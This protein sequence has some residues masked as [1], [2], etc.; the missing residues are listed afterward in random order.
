VGTRKERTVSQNFTIDQERRALEELALIYSTEIQP[1]F[2]SLGTCVYAAVLASRTLDEIGLKCTHS[3]VDAYFFG[4]DQIQKDEFTRWTL[5]RSKWVG[6]CS[7]N[8]VVRRFYSPGLGGGVDGHFIIETDNFFVDFTAPQFDSPRHQLR[9]PRALIVPLGDLRE[10]GKGVWSVPIPQGRYIF[11]D[12][13]KPKPPTFWSSIDSFFSPIV[14]ECV[15]R[16]K[17]AALDD[18]Y[19]AFADM[20]SLVSAGIN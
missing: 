13:E 20:K 15:H 5:P 7:T 1:E 9:I 4:F 18:S 6:A 10:L 12:A 11:C 16:M 17:T 19:E 14:P 3:H 2:D 8:S